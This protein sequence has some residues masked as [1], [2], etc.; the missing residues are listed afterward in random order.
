[1]R[2]KSL[3]SNEIRV[4]PVPIEE[5]RLLITKEITNCSEVCVER[6]DIHP[7]LERSVRGKGTLGHDLIDRRKRR[8]GEAV[9]GKQSS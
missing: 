1:M 6:T 2:L 5:V 4:G 3:F 7:G 8:E 9:E